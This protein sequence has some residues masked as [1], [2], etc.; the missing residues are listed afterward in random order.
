M[1]NQKEQRMF[2]IALRVAVKICVLITDF[3]YNMLWCSYPQEV[4]MK[5]H[6]T[7]YECASGKTTPSILC[8]G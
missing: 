5:H 4:C 8:L 6:A 2:C 3:L 7:E 1:G